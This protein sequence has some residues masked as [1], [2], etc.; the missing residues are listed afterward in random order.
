MVDVGLG[1]VVPAR[2]DAIL[3]RSGVPISCST[4]ASQ[5]IDYD[6]IAKEQMRQID[7]S[8]RSFGP[9]ETPSTYYSR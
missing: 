1:N 9:D 3:L 4:V 7:S 2:N 8:G 5:P 6:V